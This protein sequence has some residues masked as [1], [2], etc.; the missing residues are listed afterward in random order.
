MRE[1]R[2]FTR[3]PYEVDAEITCKDKVLRGETSNLCLNGLYVQTDEKLEMNSL[4]ELTIPPDNVAT[5]N[6]I[7]VKGV[8]VRL[9][10]HGMGFKFHQVDVD[11][12]ITLKNI[13][14]FHCGNENK[15]MDEFYANISHKERLNH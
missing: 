15:V 11:A 8:V 9:D 13:V 14:S 3:V 2:M 4:A 7:T 5:R 6:A 10:E 12:F 1:V